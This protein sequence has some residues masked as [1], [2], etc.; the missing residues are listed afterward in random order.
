M[1]RDLFHDQKDVDSRA[2]G[3]SK[4][5]VPINFGDSLVLLVSK[6]FLDFGIRL[7]R[8]QAILS[9]ENSLMNDKNYNA[10]FNYLSPCIDRFYLS[11]FLFLLYSKA[12]HF[13]GICALK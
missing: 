6:C 8:D 3:V 11:S 7:Y 12:L 4:K 1:G 2:S 13:A 9:I 10:R 5:N